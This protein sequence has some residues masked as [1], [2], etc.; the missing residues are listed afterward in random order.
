M[1]K[2][3]KKHAFFEK[4]EG[5]LGTAFSD[6]P[7]ITLSA[8]VC[9]V[10]NFKALLDFSSESIRINTSDGVVRIMGRGLEI[11]VVTD[12]NISVRGKIGSLEFE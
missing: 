8:S 7:A 6:S 3:N 9:E 4:A 1:A 2:K 10:D 11:S 12:E 5:V